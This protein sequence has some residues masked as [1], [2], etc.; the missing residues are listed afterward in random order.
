MTIAR[1]ERKLTAQSPKSA[2]D[3]TDRRLEEGMKDEAGAAL[4]KTH[5]Q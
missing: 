1:D 4:Q 2:P 3:T 5:A